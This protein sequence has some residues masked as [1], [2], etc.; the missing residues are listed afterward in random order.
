MSIT[1]GD[2]LDFDLILDLTDPGAPLVGTIEQPPDLVTSFEAPPPIFGGGGDVAGITYTQS[3]PAGTWTIDHG[4][5]RALVVQVF[6]LT[7]ELVE[8]DVISNPGQAVITFH[9]PTAGFAVLI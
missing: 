1:I 9:D 7:G 6:L 4:A 8:A 5:S 2:G 3:S